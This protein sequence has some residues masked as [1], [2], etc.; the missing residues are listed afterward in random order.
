MAG[1]SSVSRGEQQKGV[2]GKRRREEGES[3]GLCSHQDVGRKCVALAA[4]VDHTAEALVDG[5]HDQRVRDV[6]HQ[7]RRIRAHKRPRS[8]MLEHRTR[9]AVDAVLVVSKLKPLL[10]AVHR[11]HDDVVAKATAAPD[12]RA[13]G[14]PPPSPPPLAPAPAPVASPAADGKPPTAAGVA[15]PLLLKLALQPS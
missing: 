8:L 5:A 11:C 10:D 2:V 6:H 15:P 14:A 9:A 13:E 7:S 1:V 4:R 3:A 12:A